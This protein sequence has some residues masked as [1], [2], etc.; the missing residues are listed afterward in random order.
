MQASADELSASGCSVSGRAEDVNA[1]GDGRNVFSAFAVAAVQRRV[2]TGWTMALLICLFMLVFI[3]L[4]SVFSLFPGGTEAL[5]AF[6]LS[7]MG[8]PY[9]PEWGRVV[10]VATFAAVAAVG[11][12]VA[13]AL[14]RR[15]EAR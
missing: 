10:P 7:L 8:S 9:A 11:A 6:A 15:A 2:G 1:Y 4:P 3:G 12:A 13:W 14:M 5:G